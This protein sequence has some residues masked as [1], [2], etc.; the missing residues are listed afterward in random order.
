M[1]YL[2]GKIGILELIGDVRRALEADAFFSALA[3]TFA[4][5][6]KCAGIDFPNEKINKTRYQSFIKKYF[7][8]VD[9]NDRLLEN[10]C[11]YPELSPE[12]IYQLRCYFLH[13]VSTNIDSNR[14][15][16]I[17]NRITN[18][19]F[20]VSHDSV[21]M[22]LSVR[23]NGL[24]SVDISVVDF[25]EFVLLIIEKFVSELDFKDYYNVHKCIDLCDYTSSYLKLKI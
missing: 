8:E 5:I 23:S 6:D 24:Q 20:T 21:P 13:E 22:C 17:S 10:G 9:Y 16:D 2:E 19:K 4:L 25:V 12:V 15:Y 14:I 3:L 1:Q 7:D 18:F 11:V